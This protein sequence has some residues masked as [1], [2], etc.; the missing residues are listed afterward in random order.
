MEETNASV[1]PAVRF[2]GAEQYITLPAQR[3]TSNFRALLQIM[4]KWCL[5]KVLASHLEIPASLSAWRIS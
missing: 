4:Y 5:V 3:H 1:K 2:S